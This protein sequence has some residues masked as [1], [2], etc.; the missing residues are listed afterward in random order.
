MKNE[1]HIEVSDGDTVIVA[2]EQ[3]P[4]TEDEVGNEQLYGDIVCCTIRGQKPIREDFICPRFYKAV[5]GEK[6][7]KIDC[8]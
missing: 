1:N 8:R 6:G 2:W 4:L 3:C 5:Y 7:F